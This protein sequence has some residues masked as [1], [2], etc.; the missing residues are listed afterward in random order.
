[1][2]ER[3]LTVEQL[4]QWALAGAHWRV[5]ELTADHAVVELCECTGAPVER[6]QSNQRDLLRYLRQARSDLDV[7]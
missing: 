1:M 6:V 7:T 5:V 4:K 3:E 2:E